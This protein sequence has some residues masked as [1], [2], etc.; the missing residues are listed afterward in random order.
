MPQHQVI[1]VPAPLISCTAPSALHSTS[2]IRSTSTEAPRQLFPANS[3]S[4]PIHEATARLA[5]FIRIVHRAS[6]IGRASCRERVEITGGAGSGKKNR[7]DER[8][9]EE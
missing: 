6:K 2:S 9:A 3:G 7:E 5:R 1:G 4:H 8:E